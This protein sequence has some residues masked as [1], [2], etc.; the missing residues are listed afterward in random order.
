MSLYK[1]FLIKDYFIQVHIVMDHVDDFLN[2]QNIEGS[3][4]GYI[5]H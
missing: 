3:K 1:F 5:N 4:K 2:E